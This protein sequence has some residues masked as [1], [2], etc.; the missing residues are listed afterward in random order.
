[1][2]IKE[3]LDSETTIYADLPSMRAIQNPVS[4]SPGDILVIPAHPGIVLVGGNEV[5][6]IE[7]TIPH[8]SLESIS[9]ARVCKS[10]KGIYL[11]ALSDLE[12][13]DL[14]FSFSII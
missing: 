9:N 6:I 4:T 8:N 5:T 2:S 10:Q 14:T 1:M 11:K 12:V 7:L 3:H 13:K